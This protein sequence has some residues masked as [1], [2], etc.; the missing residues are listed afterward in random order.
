M[1]LAFDFCPLVPF[2]FCHSS[3]LLNK[4][5]QINGLAQVHWKGPPR[6]LP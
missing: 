1:N 4:T 5:K 2:S 3:P 6:Y